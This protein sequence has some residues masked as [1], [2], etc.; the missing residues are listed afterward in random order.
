MRTNVFRM[1]AMSLLIIVGFVG[2]FAEPNVTLTGAAWFLA[3][4]VSKAIGL[5]ALLYCGYLGRKWY[6]WDAEID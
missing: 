3:L 4:I 1:A 5:A 6:N 2:L